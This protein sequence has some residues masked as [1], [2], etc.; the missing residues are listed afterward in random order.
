M[1]L[2]NTVKASIILSAG[3]VVA[4]LFIGEAAKDMKSNER[5]VTVK[6]LA[7][8]EV[9]ANK[10]IW[11]IAFNDVSNDLNSLYESI[12]SKNKTIVD[13]LKKNGVKDSEI[14]VASPSVFDRMAQSYV[15]ENVKVR[16]QISE[17]I[18]VTSSDVD[19]IMKLMSKQPEMLRLGIAVGTNYENRVQYLYT[20]LNELKPEM[21]EEATKNAR[22]VA[23]KFAEDAECNLG[24]IKYANQGQ[25]SI[26]EDMNTP[27]IKKIR[28]VTTVDYFL[29]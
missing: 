12:E 9:K 1:K 19:K 25:F 24:S 3:I 27:H 2:E 29:K 23:D 22:Q 10:V 5:Y 8:R 21:I 28:V 11:P 7:E 17:V 13:Y 20:S 26:T 6:G 14:S 15:S 16:Y 18:T 4:S